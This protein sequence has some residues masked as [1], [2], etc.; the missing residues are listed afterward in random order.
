MG[1]NEVISDIK[2]IKRGDTDALCLR[3]ADEFDIFDKP[4]RAT[5]AKSFVYFSFAPQAERLNVFRQAN[6]QNIRISAIWNRSSIGKP[7]FATF[8]F[9]FAPIGHSAE[10]THEKDQ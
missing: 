10:R 9:T 8:R 2:R 1:Q 4:H 7:R 6:V 5:A 3:F